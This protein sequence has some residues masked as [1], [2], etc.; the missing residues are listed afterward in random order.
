MLFRS[1]EPVRGVGTMAWPL[2]D[3][4]GIL[5][6]FGARYDGADF[7]SGTDI[8]AEHGAPVIAAAGGTVR[9]ANREWTPGVGYGMYV[10]IDHGGD[11]MTLYG[12]CSEILVAEGDTVTE[13]QK[14]AKV[15]ATGFAGQPHLHFEV[16]KGK[17]SVNPMPYISSVGF[18]WPTDGGYVATGVDGYPGHT[19]ID[20]AGQP[21]GT[22]VYAA[23][24]GTVT[25]AEE[26]Y[27]GYGKYLIIDHGDGFE[28]LYAHNSKLL[29]SVGDIVSQGGTIAETGASG[30]ATGTQLHF[31]V[32][33]NG[34]ILDPLDFLEIPGPGIPEPVPQA[35]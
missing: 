17:E 13:G 16:R 35:E 14:I 1:G 21:S 15:G 32:R 19:G 2:P 27:T 34:K 8:A 25:L 7:H 24:G 9:I 26:T 23:A 3:H 12:H 6:P 20:I 4:Y 30:N 10:V 33:R 11:V 31:E 18:D 22:P 29:V 28:T 5:S